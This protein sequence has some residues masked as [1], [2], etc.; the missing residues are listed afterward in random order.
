[1]N[2]SKQKT[3]THTLH[4]CSYISNNNEIASAGILLAFPKFAPTAPECAHISAKSVYLSRNVSHNSPSL[5]DQSCTFH[6][7]WL[8]LGTK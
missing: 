4:S 2:T 3:E 7:K 1:M 5:K 8:P 6:N